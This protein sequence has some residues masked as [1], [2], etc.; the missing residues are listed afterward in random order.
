MSEFNQDTLLNVQ[1]IEVVYEQSILAVKQVSLTVPQ[2]AIVALLGANGA[3]KSTTLKA[4][5]QLIAAENGQILR[6]QI[7]YQ[8]KSILGQN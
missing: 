7:E 5:S 4:I 8:G 2:A 3:G 6:G 1:D